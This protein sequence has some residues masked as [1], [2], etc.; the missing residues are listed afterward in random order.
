MEILLNVLAVIGV[1]AGSLVAVAALVA[2]IIWV[3]IKLS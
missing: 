2:A 3:A 1:V